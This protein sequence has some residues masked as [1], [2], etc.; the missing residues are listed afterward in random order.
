MGQQLAVAFNQ[1]VVIENRSA[2]VVVIAASYVARSVPDGYT[3]LMA[4]A[5]HSAIEPVQTLP[6]TP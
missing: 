6:T 1:S 5:H 3:L 2:R 4:T